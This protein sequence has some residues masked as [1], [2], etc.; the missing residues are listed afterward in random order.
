M[1]SS[2]R[3]RVTARRVQQLPVWQAA[4]H[5]HWLANTLSTV[6][7]LLRRRPDA[8]E[9]LLAQFVSYLRGLLRERRAL[10]PLADEMSVVRALVGVERA[11]MGGRLRFDLR[12]PPDTLEIAVPPLIVH[13]LVENAIR[14]GVARRLQGG[15]VRVSA[16]LTAGVLHLVVSDDGPGFLRPLPARAATG[17]GLSGVRQRLAALWGSQARLRV[18]ARPGRGTLATLTIPATPAPRT[19]T[20]APST[21]GVAP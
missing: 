2:V 1:G 6:G 7:S 5:V 14:H 20:R 10:V 8:A 13:P 16:R 3:S 4:A 12:C 15:H 11:R 17:W 21:S 19:A 18:L 9:D